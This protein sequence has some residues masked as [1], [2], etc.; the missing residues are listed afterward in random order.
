LR[1]F[2]RFWN[3]ATTDEL[4]PDSPGHLVKSS[5]PDTF[6]DRPER[7][8]WSSAGATGLGSA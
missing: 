4:T 3:A 2:A 1:R 5:N 6:H 8:K 7:V